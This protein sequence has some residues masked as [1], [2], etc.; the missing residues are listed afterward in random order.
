MLWL[1]QRQN[2]NH[3]YKSVICIITAYEKALAE[4]S[5]EVMY[6]RVMLI[7]P[8]GVGKSCFKRGLMGQRFNNR[9]NS[10][11]VADVQSL[12]PSEHASS[13]RKRA[14]NHEQTLG[15][16]DKFLIWFNEKWCEVTE[17]DEIQE[18]AELLVLVGQ[19]DSSTTAS[20]HS[21]NE[22]MRRRFQSLNRKFKSRILEKAFARAEVMNVA[23]LKPR[24]FF[25]LWDCGGQPMFLEFLPIF[26]TSRTIFLRFFNAA[27]DLKQ[28]W[29]SSYRTDGK[30]V[31][32]QGKVNMSTLEMMQRWIALIYSHLLKKEDQSTDC[33]AL[34]DPGYP[35]VIPIGTRGDELDS[36]TAEAVLR[37]VKDS[38]KGKP[39]LHH[40][41]KQPVIID[42]TTSGIGDKED[43]G[44]KRIREEIS[45]ITQSKLKKDTPLSW[46][47]FR[48]LL[49]LFPKTSRN[50]I[51]I[52]SVHDV[53]AI[54]SLAKVQASDVEAVLG[55]Y[56]ELGVLLYYPNVK[57]L[58]QKV[59]LNPQWFVECLGK[60]LALPG[61]TEE[62]YEDK[63]EWELFRTKG[64]LVQRLYTN[65]WRECQ[66][67]R[68]E[69]FM[70]LLTH[71]QLAVEV[72]VEAEVYLYEHSKK[73]FVPSVLPYYSSDNDQEDLSVTQFAFSSAV[74]VGKISII[75]A[76]P[77]HVTFHA[78]F[79]V[80]GFFTRL[81][82]ALLQDRGESYPIK[83]RLYFE[84]DKNN[85][86]HNLITY[87]MQSLPSHYVV[88]TEHAN[89]IEISFT[90]LSIGQPYK[91][92]QRCCV[93]LKVC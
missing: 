22:T 63:A 8:A 51:N 73:Y 71:F 55:F 15:A 39:A 5:A 56:H 17:E 90:C 85:I 18:I 52:I 84:K 48:N 47:L 69:E 60:V 93:N 54:A 66:G 86:F 29:E 37:E 74:N 24:P 76:A 79:V 59:I 12:I 41:L 25:H 53:H 27:I 49:H 58:E 34:A 43:P 44:Y 87:E 62:R 40:V 16:E 68:P 19:I 23:N 67:V 82:T 35:R 10:T 13:G 88:L 81:A 32:S 91:K 64:I 61:A 45:N 11:I 9:M 26:L 42:N 38:I 65:V 3:S 20:S 31:V 21:S 2:I 4:G 78:G 92:I 77:L 80:P 1:F 89:T 14:L 30:E 70:E 50:S 57:G 83:L 33:D 75:K 72:K 6:G 46:I 7:G 28:P 36:K